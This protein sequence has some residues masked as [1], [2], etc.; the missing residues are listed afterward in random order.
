LCADRDSPTTSYARHRLQ[1]LAFV[2]QEAFNFVGITEQ[3][4]RNQ[5]GRP[6]LTTE[7]AKSTEKGSEGKIIDGKIMKRI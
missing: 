4:S 3:R 1:S 7:N 6:D 2:R 5:E